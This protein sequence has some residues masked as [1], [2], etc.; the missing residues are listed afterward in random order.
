MLSILTSPPLVALVNNPIRFRVQTDNHI[1]EMGSDIVL[2]VQFASTGFEDDWIELRWNGSSIRLTCK[3]VPDD[4]GNQVHDNSAYYELNE[5]VGELARSLSLNY[6]ISNDFHV[7]A[8]GTV[9]TLLAKAPGDQF[10]IDSEFSWT[11]AD[12]PVAGISGQN[13]TYRPFFKAGLQVQVKDGDL[14]NTVGEDL[15]PVDDIGITTFDIH[16]LLADQVHSE[17]RFPEATSPLILIR[18]E[19]CLEYRVRYYEQYGADQTAQVVTESESFFVLSGGISQLQ[20]AIYSRK[21]TSFW[22]KL[23]YNGY[24][25]TWQPKEKRIT[26]YQT[27]KLFFLLQEAVPGLILRR[28]FFLKDG[29]GNHSEPVFSIDSPEPKKVYELTVTPS[30]QMVPGW[31]TD[32]LD[33]FQVW[34]EDGQMNRISEIRTYRM[35]YRTFSNARLFFFRNSLGGYDTLR[36]TGEQEDSLEYDRSSVHPALGADLSERDHRFNN[37]SISESRQFKANTGWITPENSAWIRDFFLSKQVYRIIGGK[38]VPAVIT[39]TQVIQHRDNKELHSMDFEYRL[40]CSNEQYTLEITG[41][42]MNDD[43]NEDF[44]DQ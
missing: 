43:F 25:L 11:S 7:S 1:E 23:Q 24:F 41:A 29:S 37:Y 38:L 27:E 26:R 16:R 19:A 10:S 34:M 36:I 28:A 4:S 13:Q 32:C 42:V 17:F 30:V 35:D 22:E 2:T 15:Q 20:E 5:W 6:Y 44:A 33:Y 9:L 39:S 14:W 21:G 40:S 12:K 18:P 3:S 31:D 8:T